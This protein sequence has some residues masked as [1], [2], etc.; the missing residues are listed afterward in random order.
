MSVLRNGLL[1]T[2]N[3]SGAAPDSSEWASERQGNEKPSS[4]SFTA[5]FNRL[6]FRSEKLKIRWLKLKWLTRVPLL[7]LRCRFKATRRYITWTWTCRRLTSEH[8]IWCRASL[9]PTGGFR[10]VHVAF[11][12]VIYSLFLLNQEKTQSF[13]QENTKIS[14]SSFY[15][16]S[17]DGFNLGQNTFRGYKLR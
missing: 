4:E 13:Q 1:D 9:L 3:T 7:S 2:W 11:V 16:L 10:T 6:L 14:C 5:R 12:V 15:S 17:E 8:R